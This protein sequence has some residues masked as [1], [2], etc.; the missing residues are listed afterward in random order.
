MVTVYVP[1]AA[2]PPPEAEPFFPAAGN[3]AQLQED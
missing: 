2:V 1:A 3:D